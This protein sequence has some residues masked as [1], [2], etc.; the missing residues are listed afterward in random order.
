MEEK[1]IKKEENYINFLEEDFLVELGIN[2]KEYS[3]KFPL[4][5]KIRDNKIYRLKKMDKNWVEILLSPLPVFIIGVVDNVDVGEEKLVLALYKYNKWKISIF[6]KTTIY[7]SSNIVNLSSFGVPVNSSND[8]H[9]V[10]Y[11][12]KLE[13]ENI[14]N[15]IPI[16]AVAKLGW[17]ENN[18]KFVPFSEDIMLD[19]DYKLQKWSDGYK[20]KGVLEDWI[21]EIRTLRDNTLFRFIL[22]SSFASPLLSILGHRIFVVYNYGAS[23]AGKTAMLHTALSVWGNAEDLMCTFNT[24]AVGIERLAGFYNDLVLGIDEKQIQKSQNEL[25]KLIFM[26]SSGI[27]KIRGNKTGG[28]QEI[29]TFNVLVLSTGEQPITTDNSTTGVSTRILELDGSPFNY[30]EELSS[31]MYE[32]TKKY[33]G[34]AGRKYIEILL[35]NYSNNDYEELKTMFEEIKKELKTKTQNDVQSYISSVA[36][37]VLADIITSKGL[38]EE[39]EKEKSIQ[40]GLEI[41][42]KLGTAKEIDVVE[43]AYENIKSWIISNYKFFD[44]VKAPSERNYVADDVVSNNFR[45]SF[46][47]YDNGIYYIHRNILKDWLEQNNY[48]YKKIIN[49]FAEKGYILVSRDENGKIKDKAV[50]KKF[51]GIN[52]RMYAFKFDVDT[53]GPVKS[54]FPDVYDLIKQVGNLERELEKERKALEREKNKNSESRLK[55]HHPNEAKY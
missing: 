29:N 50:Q 5:Y 13:E 9:F 37:V 55:I 53:E 20:Q 40:M 44:M 10:D 35:N 47:L 46:G 54:D 41:L 21:N 2:G 26:L 12:S 51:R 6:P 22:S 11:F 16:T 27:G 34:T 18:T 17:R 25:E 31:N 32:I 24:T 3:L 49:G 33:Y 7:N 1:L 52:H 15:L 23:R 38:F 48:S 43:K 42:D 19:L 28:V 30:D 45:E 4:K 39:E 36:V 8:S 14:N